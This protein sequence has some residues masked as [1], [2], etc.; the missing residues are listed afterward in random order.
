MIKICALYFYSHKI[1]SSFLF[2]CFNECNNVS[3][4][5]FVTCVKAN[6]AFTL[7][8]HEIH[9]NAILF[10]VCVSALPPEGIRHFEPCCWLLY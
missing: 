2:F 3:Q 7:W 9:V 8:H 5:L 6:G 4:V 1:I 10:I